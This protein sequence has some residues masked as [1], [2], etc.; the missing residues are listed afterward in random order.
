[1]IALLL[2]AFTIHSVDV[3]FIFHVMWTNNPCVK[4]FLHDYSSLST[5][6]LG[7]FD[8]IRDLARSVTN[9]HSQPGAMGTW[10]L[11]P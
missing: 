3:I 5:S 11:D 6:L 2:A 9:T 10:G 4:V 7:C 1:M 8:V